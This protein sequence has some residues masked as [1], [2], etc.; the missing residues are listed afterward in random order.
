[1]PEVER[2][3]SDRK[4]AYFGRLALYFE[5]YRKILLVGADNVGSSH[6]QKIRQSLR[7]EAVILMGKNVRFEKLGVLSHT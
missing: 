7:G 2:H 1:M 4:T 3:Y 5:E 6:M